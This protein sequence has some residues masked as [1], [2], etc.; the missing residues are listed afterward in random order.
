M[1][2]TPPGKALQQATH[3]LCIVKDGRLLAVHEPGRRANHPPCRVSRSF[4]QCR[5]IHIHAHLGGPLTPKSLPNTLMPHAHAKE[6]EAR[7]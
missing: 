6:G 5:H 1:W 7:S 4:S 3:I 2:D